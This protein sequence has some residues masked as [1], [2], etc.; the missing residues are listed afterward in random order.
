LTAIVKVEQVPSTI[1]A[2][3]VT[4]QPSL[5]TSFVKD[6][7]TVFT[8]RFNNHFTFLKW[9]QANDALITFHMRSS[10]LTVW[11]PVW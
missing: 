4:N 1:W 11:L 3:I 6:V 7:V 9:L 8:D 2:L 10:I 5:D